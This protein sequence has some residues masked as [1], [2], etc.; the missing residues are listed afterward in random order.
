MQDNTRRAEDHPF[1]A[2]GE[3]PLNGDALLSSLLHRLHSA[4][5]RLERVAAGPEQFRESL[6]DS[7]LKRWGEEVEYVFKASQL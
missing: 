7:P 2:S 4:A 3:S 6:P 1:A 5:D